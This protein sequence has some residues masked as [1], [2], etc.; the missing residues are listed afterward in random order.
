MAHPGV[1]QKNRPNDFNFF[2]KLAVNWSQF[3]ALDG[4]TPTD[5]YGPDI[6]IPFSTQAFS[7]INE[8]SGATNTIEY[9]FDGQ[10]VHGDLIP[11]TLSASLVFNN[12]VASL[13]WFRLKAGSSG[14]VNLRIEAWGIR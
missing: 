3:G 14:P 7:F 2:T 6:I 12:R 11:G 1:K 13:I 5:G 4:Y 8:G 10:H 9:S